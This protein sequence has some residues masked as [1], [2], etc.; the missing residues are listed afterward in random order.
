[1]TPP[2]LRAVEVVRRD[3][4]R[5]RWDEPVEA[6]G[7]RGRQRLDRPAR[8]RR[9]TPSC[10][11]APGRPRDCAGPDQALRPPPDAA[12]P[13]A[14]R[15]RPERGAHAARRPTAGT[16]TSPAT[17][18]AP[19]RPSPSPTSCGPA[20]PRI[21][22]LDGV[23]GARGARPA[24]VSTRTAPVLTVTGVQPGQTV[25]G[26]RDRAAAASSSSPRRSRRRPARR[27]ALPSTCRSPRRSCRPGR[28]RSRPS[29]STRAA[30]G[31]PPSC[32]RPA[33]TP[34]GTVVD[35]VLDLAP[36]QL[37]A[38]VVH[39]PTTV[40]VTLT[41][42][43]SGHDDPADWTL[44]DAARP[45]RRCRR[46]VPTPQPHGQRA[47]TARRRPAPPRPR[48][49]PP[50]GRRGRAAA[51]RR[52]GA[53][54]RRPRAGRRR[55]ARAGSYVKTTTH[56]LTGTAPAGTVVEVFGD[57]NGDG[58]AGRDAAARQ[59]RRSLLVPARRPRGERDPRAVA[60]QSATPRAGSS[61]ASSTC[62]PSC[63]TRS[64][65]RLA[66]TGPPQ[67]SAVPARTLR[68]LGHT[69]TDANP[70]GRVEV[71]LSLDGGTVWTPLPPAAVTGGSAWAVPATATDLAH[72]PADRRGRRGPPDHARCPRCSASTPRR[73]R[74]RPAPPTCRPSRSG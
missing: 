15:R 68:A 23:A 39:D 73:R 32:T 74:C 49:G 6:L 17:A 29:S 60:A 51:R 64:R 16:P 19:A 62:R 58:A 72:A 30:T 36:P 54:Q 10:S 22:A 33:R 55:P 38:G 35:H 13:A 1:M 40:R 45:S 48:P 28:P 25:A 46:P 11:S 21:A 24:L 65:R 50:A 66:F 12:G 34:P 69:V 52:D 44:V 53:G 56:T 59:Q 3:E 63:R 47:G 67:G 27:R 20:R 14:R 71:E 61:A 42:P 37:A 26:P 43:V 18:T 4:V 8:R 5:V 9:A 41:E 70:G 2:Q 7:R 57:A 31:A